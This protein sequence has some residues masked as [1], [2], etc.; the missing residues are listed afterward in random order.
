M[1]EGSWLGSPPSP[2]VRL[3]SEAMR[4]A[5]TTETWRDLAPLPAETFAGLSRYDCAGA[6]EEALTI[7]LLLRRKL[8]TPGATAALVTPDRELARRVAASCGAGE[9]RSTIRRVCR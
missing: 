5:A 6:H 1:D 4:P 8:E 9:S 7:A 3:I 2:R